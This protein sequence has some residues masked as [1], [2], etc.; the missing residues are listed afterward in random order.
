MEDSESAK[1]ALAGGRQQ[2]RD[3]LFGRIDAVVIFTENDKIFSL[4]TGGNVPD[5]VAQFGR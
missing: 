1:A 2:G 4:L 3:K 5:V